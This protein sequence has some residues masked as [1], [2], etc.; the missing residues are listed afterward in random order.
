MWGL[1][2]A[3]DLRGRG[4]HGSHPYST[5]PAHP[6]TLAG[7]RSD[8]ALGVQEEGRT[9]SAGVE[10]DGLLARG[11]GLLPPG[12]AGP[13]AP[14]LGRA[15]G[16][17]PGEGGPPEGWASRGAGSGAHRDVVP[18]SQQG[19]G[20]EAVHAHR[21]V[22]HQLLQ[23]EAA[24]VH[25]LLQRLVEDAYE[26][27]AAANRHDLQ[28]GARGAGAGAQAGTLCQVSGVPP[29]TVP[30]GDLT[31]QSQLG[32]RLTLDSARKA[33]DGNPPQTQASGH[34]CPACL[35][36]FSGDAGRGRLPGRGTPIWRVQGPPRTSPVR[37]DPA[38]STLE[39]H[40]GEEQQQGSDL[41]RRDS[42]P[43]HLGKQRSAAQYLVGGG[44]A[45]EFK[46]EHKGSSRS[47]PSPP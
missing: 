2:L 46:P 15:G 31:L 35:S 25:R 26:P 14:H 12:A 8:L 44:A 43:Q 17:A 30:L 4:K 47:P 38:R 18:R 13:L 32:P 23:H 28:A 39:V 29:A 20:W 36:G 34:S 19:A 10:V 21:E 3:E 11:R 16:G 6:P 5:K 40:V 7:T 27:L 45:S 9:A 37:P 22:E 24:Q 42:E 1:V 33:R 41:S